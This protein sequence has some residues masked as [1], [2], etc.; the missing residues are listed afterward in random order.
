M[1]NREFIKNLT[2]TCTSHEQWLCIMRFGLGT[3]LA[4]PSLLME[5]ITA[6]ATELAAQQNK[7]KDEDA[8]FP[9]EVAPRLMSELGL[10]FE[11]TPR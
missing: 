1:S 7:K 5:C 2:A 9:W 11:V 3:L 6:H 10:R 4:D 8:A